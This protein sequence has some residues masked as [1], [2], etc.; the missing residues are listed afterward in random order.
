VSDLSNVPPEEAPYVP[1]TAGGE[2]RAARVAAGLDIDVIAQQLKLAPRQVQA[3]ENDDYAKLPGRTFV[4]GFVRN[5]ARLLQL[6]PDDVVALLPGADVA[7]SLERPTITP[8]RRAMGELPAD[9]PAR[10]AWARWVIPLVLIAIIVA[11]G[12]YEFRRPQGEPRRVAL[13]KSAPVPTATPG[14]TTAT[15][16]NPLSAPA[17]ATPPGEAASAAAPVAGAGTPPAAVAALEP[18]PASTA[19]A[20]APPAT[21]AAD[22]LLVVTF[23]GSS[24]VQVKDRNGNTL[25][26][27]TGQPGTTQSVSGALP[28]DVVI[29][30]A[31]NVTATFRG[32]AVDLTSSTRGS[33][34]RISL[35]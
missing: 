22:P 5:Y 19:P 17:D 20:A 12:I 35:K 27:Q 23:K 2:L 1:P 14:A 11:A 25:L 33:V 6:D 32:Q 9:T 7:P 24:W 28:L 16:P 30:N 8:S 15:L 21:A 26:A 34:A 29:G 18:A 10:R 31:P 4:R 13:E 3:L